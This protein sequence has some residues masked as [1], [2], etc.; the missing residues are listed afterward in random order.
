[1]YIDEKDSIDNCE[2]IIKEK[3][4]RKSKEDIRSKP[5]EHVKSLKSKAQ[6]PQR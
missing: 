1:M 4:Q 2:I 5:N 6:R 3:F